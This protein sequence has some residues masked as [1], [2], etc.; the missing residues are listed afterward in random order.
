M[1]S[2]LLVAS[3]LLALLVGLRAPA[4]TAAAAV[5]ALAALAT[6]VNQLE[7]ATYSAL[8]D[9]VFFVLVLGAPATLGHLLAA[10]RRELRELRARRAELEAALEDARAA[11]VAEE[12]ARLAL[13]VHD[14]LAH[15]LGD[16]ALQAAAAERLGG[17]AGRAALTAAEHAGR[18]ALDEIRDAIGVLRRSDDPLREPHPEPV[19]PAFVP[20]ARAAAAVPG[21]RAWPHWADPAIAAALGAAILVE[22]LTSSHLAGPPALNVLGVAAT[23]A[24]LAWRRRAPLPAVAATFAAA[25]TQSALLTPF[26]L[27]VTP[28][29]LLLLP[30]YAVAAHAPR[31]PALLGLAVCL[32]GSVALEPSAVT[33]AL[34]LAAWCAGRA[35]RAR[36]ARAAELA[37]VNERLEASRDA[38]RARARGEERLRLARELHDAIAHRLT[39]VVLQAGAAQ[40]VLATDPQAARTA[41]AALT[42]EARAAL[43]ELRGTLGDE[44]PE[45]T[46]LH[47]LAARM[48]PL[49][50][51]VVLAIGPGA[52]PVGPQAFRVVQEAL[53][54]AVRHAAPTTVEVRVHRDGDRLRVSVVDR[55]REGAGPAAPPGSGSGLA[56][57]AERLAAVGGTLEA[58]PAGPGFAVRAT[59]PAAA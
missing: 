17:E 58:G 11:A 15:R 51:D 32:A 36:S 2:G 9:A 3:V 27:L 6:V 37:R 42:R 38:H 7:D 14:A 8:D 49:G 44:A 16:I 30:A 1:T 39:V 12:R 47:E 25:A 5:V 10:R 59:L 21:R 24:P 35:V 41:T 52:E 29:A 57:M 18:A 20:E 40:R 56:G 55:G 46:D 48:R 28:I 23:A 4:R 22:V 26:G 34:G 54:N 50:L 45:A 19:P 53:T 13:A 43:A 31:R 33:G